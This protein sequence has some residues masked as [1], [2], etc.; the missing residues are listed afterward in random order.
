MGDITQIRTD[1][2]RGHCNFL[3]SKQSNGPA[4]KKTRVLPINSLNKDRGLAGLSNHVL[5][6]TT[7]ENLKGSSQDPSHG[8][9]LAMFQISSSGIRAQSRRPFSKLSPGL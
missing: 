6:R 3:P 7:E 2:W 5:C 4:H 1:K 8:K 9:F